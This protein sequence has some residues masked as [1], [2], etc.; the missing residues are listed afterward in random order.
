MRRSCIVEKDILVEYVVQSDTP[1]SIISKTILENTRVFLSFEV[2]AE[3]VEILHKKH[4]F[5]KEYIKNQL[6][7]ILELN[8]IETTDKALF[9][10]A[11]HK[12]AETD[13]SFVENLMFA[14][15]G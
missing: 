1:S 2:L 10:S 12:F 4:N 6:L 5:G 3:T 7:N 13:S 15:E 14:Y 11:L 8:N 9:T